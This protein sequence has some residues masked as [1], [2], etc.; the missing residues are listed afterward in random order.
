MIPKSIIAIYAC[1]N[2]DYRRILQLLGKTGEGAYARDS[3]IYM[4]MTTITDQQMPRG[5]AIS[6]L[7][8]AV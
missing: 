4:C 8:L 3:D 5:H 7:S 6:A 1:L 2:M